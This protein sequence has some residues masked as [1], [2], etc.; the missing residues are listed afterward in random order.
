M[1]ILQALT[2]CI[3]SA[4]RSDQFLPNRKIEFPHLCS[5]H[6]LRCVRQHRNQRKRN[7]K[8]MFM[9]C[10]SHQYIY[11]PFYK[12]LARIISCMSCRWWCAVSVRSFTKICFHFNSFVREHSEISFKFK[13]I[14]APD[15]CA[16]ASVR[17]NEFMM[18]IWLVITLNEELTSRANR[19]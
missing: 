1:N 16:P 12:Y 18:N 3:N 15:H 4:M 6:N 17:R 14:C 11:I 10:C 9:V 19:R 2:F 13:H 5:F 7:I 8:P